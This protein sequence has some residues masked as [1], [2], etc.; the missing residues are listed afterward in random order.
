[1][2]HFIFVFFFALFARRRHHR[3]LGN[4]LKWEFISS[5]RRM[6]CHTKRRTW[7]FLIKYNF[8]ADEATTAACCWCQNIKC[9]FLFSSRTAAAL[10]APLNVNNERVT[11]AFFSQFL[12]FAECRCVLWLMEADFFIDIFIAPFLC[13]RF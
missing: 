13:L 9:S 6:R 1:M 10:C 5:S 3:R 8:K 11:R 7:F 4:T 12:L 2:F